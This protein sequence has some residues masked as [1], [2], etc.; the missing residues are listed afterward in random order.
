MNRQGSDFRILAHLTEGASEADRRTSDG[1]RPNSLSEGVREMGVRG[2]AEIEGERGE[3]ILAS[4]S[5]SNA[6]RRR[7]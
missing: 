7:S 5:R 1:V 2:E 3:I 6:A 4:A